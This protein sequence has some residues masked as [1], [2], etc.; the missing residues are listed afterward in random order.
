MQIMAIIQSYRQIQVQ[1]LKIQI[2]S[3]CESEFGFGSE[4]RIEF[5]TA[6]EIEM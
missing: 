5:E 4:Y 6:Y 2:E 1:S 3:E